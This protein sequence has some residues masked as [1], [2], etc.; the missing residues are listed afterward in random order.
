VTGPDGTPTLRLFALLSGSKTPSKKRLLNATL[1]AFGLQL[2]KKMYDGVN[3]DACDAN[4]RADAMYEPNVT[5]KMHKHIFRIL[6]LND[7]NYGRH[8]FTGEVGS[9]E[10]YWKEEFKFVCSRRANFGRRPN[11]ARCD[12]LADEKILDS[13]MK[14]YEY[15]DDLLAEITYKIQ[16][17]LGRRGSFE[18][19]NAIAISVGRFLS[20]PASNQFS[21]PLIL[22]P[23][24]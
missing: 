11:R 15:Y 8:H 16:E 9:F 21:F 5:L 2:R 23:K 13:D 3:L 10:A 18:V 1:I 12:T 22:R 14:P 4:M 17:S 6:S 24:I 7:V 19:N 20:C